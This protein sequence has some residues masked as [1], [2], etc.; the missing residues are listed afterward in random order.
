MILGIVFGILALVGLGVL[1][2]FLWRRRKRSRM[3]KVQNLSSADVTSAAK[4]P[5][6]SPV[7]APKSKVNNLLSESE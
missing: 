3:T 2:F 5:E 1:G 6:S 4:Q 7:V